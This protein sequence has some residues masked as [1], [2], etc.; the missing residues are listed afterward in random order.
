MR[1]FVVTAIIILAL[2]LGVI[3]PTIAAE[4]GNIELIMV[5]EREI[6]I[7]NP[8]GSTNVQRVPADKVI[9]GDD[10]IYTITYANKGAESAENVV[11]NNPIPIHMVY[12]GGSAIGQK[13]CHNVF[14]G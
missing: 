9:P 5:A 10:V 3:G 1:T 8:D 13:L 7:T 12:V 11:V 2:I 14:S 4:E 6:K